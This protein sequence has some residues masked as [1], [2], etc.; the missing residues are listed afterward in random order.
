MLNFINNSAPN[1][2]GVMFELQSGGVT[3]EQSEQFT[4]VE[5]ARRAL[6]GN[7]WVIFKYKGD[8]KFIICSSKHN[9]SIR[10]NHPCMQK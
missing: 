10:G 6:S 1:N 8:V 9:S 2:S 4:H 3:L 5:A 7:C